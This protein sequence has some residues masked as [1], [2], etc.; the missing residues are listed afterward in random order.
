[1]HGVDGRLELIRTRL[2]AAKAHAD[3]RLTL[4]DQDP[5][6][7]GAILLAEQNEG[8]VGPRSRGAT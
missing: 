8:A 1:M 6:P 5:I 4:L 3:D 7:S 2:V